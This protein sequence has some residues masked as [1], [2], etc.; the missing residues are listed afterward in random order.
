[1]G[2]LED[3]LNRAT[4]LAFDAVGATATH[5]RRI[6][7]LLSCAL[8]RTVREVSHLAWDYQDLATDLGRG[9]DHGGDGRHDVLVADFR[10]VAR[11]RRDGLAGHAHLAGAQVIDLRRRMD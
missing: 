2:M 7:G 8:A 1:M 11:R 5:L 9:A 6:V 4:N 10:R 3:G